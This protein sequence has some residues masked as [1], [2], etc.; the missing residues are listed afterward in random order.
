MLNFKNLGK[1][2]LF[3]VLFI[4]YVFLL[5]FAIETCSRGSIYETWLY[6]TNDFRKVTFN[7][8]ILLLTLSPFLLLRKYIFYIILISVIWIFLSIGNY[9]LLSLRG[10][11]LTGADF[12]MISNGLELIPKYLSTPLIILLI[13]A[14]LGIV[15]LLF[16]A[17]I[18][19]PIKKV[20]YA[21]SIPLVIGFVLIF[22]E[23]T[24]YSLKNNII[25]KNF[26]DICG[27]Y[28]EYGFPYSFL[29][30]VVNN[31][32]SK[33]ENYSENTMNSLVQELENQTSEELQLVQAS[34]IKNV[35]ATSS[36]VSDD[37]N[38]IKSINS[39][40]ESL[41]NPNI[42]IVQLESFIDPTWIQGISFNKDPIPNFRELSSK[43]S[44][45]I[46]SVPSIGG[47]TANTEFE[48]ITGMPVDYFA[49]GE[50]PYNTLVSKKPVPSFAYHFNDLGYDTHALHNYDGT[51]Y[52]RYN[53]YKN[54]GFHTFTPLES[55]DVSEWTP[56]GWPKDTVLTNQIKSALTSSSTSDLV[57][58]VSVQGHGGY[59][60]YYMDNL[61]IRIDGDTNDYN[62]NNIE[63]YASQIYEMDKFVGDLIDMVESLNEPTIVA[64]YGDHIP[65][66]GLKADKLDSQSLYATPYLI[67]DNLNLPKEDIYLQSYELTS[68][69]LSR[70][71]LPETSITKVHNSNLDE[72]TKSNYLNLLEYDMLYGKKLTNTSNKTLHPRSDFRI[73]INIVNITSIESY[74]DSIKI[75]G[76]NF[77]IYSRVYVNG[78]ETETVFSDENTL[79]ISNLDAKPGDIISVKQISAS[80]SIEFSSSNEMTLN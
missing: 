54:L 23:I 65:S 36:D 9:I 24:N 28:S 63:Y 67:W 69:I 35:K 61:E 41:S 8:L 80:R 40:K 3:I 60:N 42:I 68:Q 11:P 1:K 32:I 46:L 66:L 26:W 25:S 33:P 71:G 52:L 49:A 73:G 79:Y 57:F 39:Y 53:A 14:L 31:G 27:G 58:A 47:G 13:V 44:S 38:D 37:Y 59:A 72:E 77:N 21:V 70:V 48:V 29:N 17:Y 34:A 51:Y 5:L 74:P 75:I 56:F 19:L 20:K 10:T 4:F 78:K 76:N 12:G 22:P 2:L 64:F 6:F 55:M 50:F 45:G 30:S 18:K 7:L 15:G 62:K 43:Y 16:F